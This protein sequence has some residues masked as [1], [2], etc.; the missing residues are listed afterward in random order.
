MG[1]T[2]WPKLN[3]FTFFH[4]KPP[5]R[6]N[7]LNESAETSCVISSEVNLSM[8][9]LIRGLLTTKVFV[10]KRSLHSSSMTYSDMAED[11][12]A[13]MEDAGLDTAI[14]LGHSMGGK[15]K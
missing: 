8:G 13:F 3:F 10:A 7:L 14:F 12:V 5:K 11:V 4:K 2:K 9:I 1:V 6:L 15:L